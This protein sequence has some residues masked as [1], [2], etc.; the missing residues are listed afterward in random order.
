MSE[1][2]L[3]HSHESQKIEDLLHEI[4]IV[5]N[6]LKRNDSAHSLKVLKMHSGKKF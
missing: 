2:H 4:V 1:L 3:P 5:R 6:L